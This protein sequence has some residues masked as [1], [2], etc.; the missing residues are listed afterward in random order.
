MTMQASLEAPRFTKPCADGNEVAIESRVPATTLQQP[1]ERGHDI[2]IRRDYTQEMGRGQAILHDSK[3]GLNYGASDPRA[4]GAATPEP[5]VRG[6]A[7]SRA[8]VL[9]TQLSPTTN[10]GVSKT[11]APREKLR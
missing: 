1:S 10:D 6:V 9:Q 7:A 2:L 4:D 11:D 3:T 5:I 8:S